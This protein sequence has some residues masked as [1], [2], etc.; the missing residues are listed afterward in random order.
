MII[1]LQLL[2]KWSED[3]ITACV[4]VPRPII[5]YKVLLFVL[6]RKIISYNGRIAIEIVP[7]HPQIVLLL[8]INHPIHGY[9]PSYSSY[10]SVSTYF[11][12]L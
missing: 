5:A 3:N 11:T 4:T 1:F 2:L 10:D 12:A 8:L 7:W 6:N 9:N